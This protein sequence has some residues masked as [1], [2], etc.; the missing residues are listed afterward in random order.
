MVASVASVIREAVKTALLD[1][2]SQTTAPRDQI[3]V[4]LLTDAKEN[5]Q[6]CDVYTYVL[7]TA[8]IS[9]SPD[10]VHVECTVEAM[11]MRS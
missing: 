11:V 5:T 8:S 7:P 6:P 10:T 9:T 2:A 3:V 1:A 4:I